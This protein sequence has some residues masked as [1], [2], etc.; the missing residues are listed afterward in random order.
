VEPSPGPSGSLQDLLDDL[1]TCAPVDRI[2]HRNAILALGPACIRPLADLAARVPELS[3]SIAAWLEVLVQRDPET[4]PE[5]KRALAIMARGRD[6]SVAGGVLDRLGGGPRTTAARPARTRTPTAR[7]AEAAVH[8]RIIRAAREGG[9]LTYSDLETSRG[10]VGKYL[11]N[12]SRAEADLGH[13]P[14]TALVVSKTNGLPGDGFLPAMLEV[15][16]AHPGETLEPVWKRAVA[17]V[18]AFWAAQPEPNG[19]DSAG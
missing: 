8:T 11:F 10:H 7:T 6:G 5:I 1:E 3:A 16:F 13:P 2:N 12:I 17:E 4:K 15:G 18:H 19:G 14:L 9:I